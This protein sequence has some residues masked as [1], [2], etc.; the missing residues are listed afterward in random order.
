VFGAVPDGVEVSRRMGPGKQVFVLVNYAAENRRV[1]LPH[2]MKLV[3]DG[4]QGSSVDLPPY[5]VAVALDS[6]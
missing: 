6:R 3:L 2:P 1:I 4:Q 5:G